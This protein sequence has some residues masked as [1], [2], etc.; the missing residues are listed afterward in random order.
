M[1]DARSAVWRQ[2]RVVDRLSIAD[3]HWVIQVLRGW[4]DE[5]LHR[6]RI[7]GRCNG[8]SVIGALHLGEDAK[9]V[10]LARFRFRPT[11]SFLYGYDFRADWRI[12]IRVE[13]VMAAVPRP[14]HPVCLAGRE[15]SPPDACGGGPQDFADRR[16]TATGWT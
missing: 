6:F 14:P 2:E 4:N 5:H 1:R 13:K 16:R 9:A 12:D 8:I 11:E 15:T 3:L 7:D 10:R